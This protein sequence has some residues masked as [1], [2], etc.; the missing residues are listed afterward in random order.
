MKYTK[1]L[2]SF[3]RNQL[4]ANLK[5]IAVAWQSLKISFQVR[6]W[7]VICN[8]AG[9][10]LE[11]AGSIVTIYASAKLVALLA[12]F[13]TTGN[14]DG[15]WFWLWVDIAAAAVSGFAFWMMR[16]SERLLYF[17]MNVWAVD[18]FLDAVS[19]VDI[20]DFYDDEMRNRINK[21]NSGHS[22]QIPN[23]SYTI[24]ELI[25][26]IIRFS[27][28]A[29]VVAQIGWWLVVVI[30]VFLV[31]TLVNDA[32][33][34]KISWLV[35]DDKGDNR[36]IFSGITWMFSSPPKQM[37]IRSMQTREYLLKRVRSINDTFYGEQEQKYKKANP[38]SI[39]AKFFEVGGVAIGS[40]V[41]LKQF[42]GGALSLERYFFLSGALLRIGGAL[43][44]IFSTLS[45][46]Q[47]PLQ[48]A[49]NFYA[50]LDAE[51]KI[52]DTENAH[53]LSDASAPTIEF[54]NV[55]FTYPGQTTPVFKNLSFTI[56]GGSHVALVGENGAGKTTII[57][58]LMR[59]YQPDKGTILIN[60]EDL[61]M[62]TIDSWYAQIATLFQD[63]NQYP[64]PIDENIYLSRPEHKDDMPRL[65]EAAKFGGVDKLVQ[66]YEH[67]WETVLD[68][69]FK[70]GI[71]PSGGQW[72]RVAL[73]RAFYRQ[74][75]MLILDEPT[76]A[77][78]AKA[79]Y[80]IFNNIFDHYGSKT[81]LIVSHRF[82]TV[83]RANR[84]IVLDKGKIVEQGSH[85]TLMQHNGLYHD[86]FTKQAEGYKN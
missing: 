72:Q 40:V 29:F 18:V 73:S 82:S 75:Q 22:W 77:I 28:M 27:A 16:Y 26:G 62:I 11:T 79:E 8:V 63:F 85:R 43:N 61:Q 56:E 42:L 36:H 68:A 86:L 46:L 80:D 45:R 84:I 39:G 7:M 69:S 13:V 78:D 38:F 4:Q 51:P 33:L 17:S 32:R 59:F 48:F 35:W 1:K 9:G 25:Y 2:R 47:D 74:A 31:P 83:R 23:L 12:A 55:S 41:L 50:L 65:N 14:S 21:A 64:L 54:V 5:L 70:K 67:G 24:L 66:K 52:K 71:E 81:A 37:E 76:S 57:K 19:R 30:A 20:A 3:Y 58:L 6:P 10:I 34:A 60:G 44:T 53:T 49:A 15:I